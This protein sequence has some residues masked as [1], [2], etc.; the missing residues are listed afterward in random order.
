MT[1]TREESYWIDTAARPRER[2]DTAPRSGT[3][4]VTTSGSMTRTTD[5]GTPTDFA[6]RET[7]AQ[8]ARSRA[9]LSESVGALKDELGALTD[10]REWVRRRPL[11]FLAGAFGLGLWLGSRGG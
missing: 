9:R 3:T 7:E 4:L 5:E 6:L 11:T 10:W 1:L 2:P 8:I